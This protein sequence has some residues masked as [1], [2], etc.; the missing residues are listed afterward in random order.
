[1][2]ALVEAQ[3]TGRRAETFV[4]G[5]EKFG[6]PSRVHAASMDAM[7]LWLNGAPRSFRKP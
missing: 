2:A 6:K 7:L 5:I 1:M 3:L 4:R